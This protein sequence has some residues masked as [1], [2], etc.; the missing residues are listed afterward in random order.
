VRRPISLLA[1]L[2][3]AA[4]PAYAAAAQLLVL[5]KS[6]ATLSFVD[7]QTGKTSKTIATGEGPHEI[8]LS[9]DGKLAFVSN[10]GARTAGHTLSVIDVEKQTEIERVDLKNLL[11]P[12]GLSF[13]SGY[14]YFTA[15]DS[16]SIGRLDPKRRR[17]DWTFETAQDRTH[18][19]LA[20]NDGKTLYTTNMGSNTVSVIEQRD[21]KWE[22]TLISVGKGPEALDLSPDGRALWTAHSQDGGISIIDP[23]TKKVVHSFDARTKRSNRLKFTPDGRIETPH[24]RKDA[25]R[26][27]DRA[28]RKARI[29]RSLGRGSHCGRRSRRDED[30]EDDPDRQ[31]SGRNGVGSIGERAMASTTA[32]S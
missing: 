31:Q 21:G 5:N 30:R 6:D 29:R 13:A 12:H 10:Y 2:V 20:T 7:P 23:A 26:H 4:A 8:E 3:M 27:L 18:M 9:S 32:E 17:V 24:A 28:A 15:E 25:D 14:A 11:R 1:A 16:H 22:Q 19:I